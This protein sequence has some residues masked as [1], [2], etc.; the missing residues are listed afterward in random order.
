MGKEVAVSFKNELNVRKKINRLFPRTEWI[1]DHTVIVEEGMLVGSFSFVTD[2]QNKTYIK[3][4]VEGGADPKR[5]IK[6]LCHNYGWMAWDEYD[7]EFLDL[8]D[9]RSNGWNNYINYLKHTGYM[10]EK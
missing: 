5:I 4:Q 3:L 10:G 1:D 6:C 7:R 8:E 9:C 2:S